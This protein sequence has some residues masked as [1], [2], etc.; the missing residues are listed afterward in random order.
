MTR[1]QINQRLQF[2]KQ[3]ERYPACPA[4]QKLADFELACPLPEPR[5]NK[6]SLLESVA[7]RQFGDVV[8]IVAQPI[9]RKIDRVMGTR[10]QHCGGCQQRREAMNEKT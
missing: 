2:C 9:A 1:I 5:W 6:V 4:S 7:K 3:C 8:A 10:I